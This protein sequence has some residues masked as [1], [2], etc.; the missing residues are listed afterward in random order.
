M[1]KMKR[2]ESTEAASIKNGWRCNAPFAGQGSSSSGIVPALDLEWV[3]RTVRHPPEAA[4]DIRK[5]VGP[6]KEQSGE[7]ERSLISP[8]AAATG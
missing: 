2:R 8:L 5:G 7:V 1:M 3:R 6:D 4:T